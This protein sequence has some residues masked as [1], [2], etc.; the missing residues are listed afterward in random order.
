M[1]LLTEI[2]EEYDRWESPHSRSYYD[3]TTILM[4]AVMSLGGHTLANGRGH[5]V[6]VVM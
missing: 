3:V 2:N 1:L 4:D 6:G 5:V